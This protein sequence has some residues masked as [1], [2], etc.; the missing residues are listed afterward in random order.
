MKF[1]M[2]NS[3]QCALTIVYEN[4]YIKEMLNTKF[5][6]VQLDNDQNSE[7]HIYVYVY[8]YDLFH[9]VLP[10]DKLMDP[11]NVCMFSCAR[12]I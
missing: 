3:P 1:V 4:K 5:L 11:W 7:N 10:C 9:N 6:G 8:V 2:K 12:I